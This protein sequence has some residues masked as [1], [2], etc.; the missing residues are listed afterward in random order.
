MWGGHLADDMGVMGD[1][2]G[3]GISGFD[4]AAYYARQALAAGFHPGWVGVA[5]LSPPRMGQLWRSRR[6]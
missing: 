4:C 3:S 5:T 1:A 2:G 6:E